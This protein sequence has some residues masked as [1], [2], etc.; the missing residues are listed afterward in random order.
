MPLCPS[1]SLR[2]GRWQRKPSSKKAIV[3]ECRQRLAEVLPLEP[4][5]VASIDGSIRLEGQK[6]ASMGQTLAVAYVYLTTL[7]HRGQHQFP[8]VI[9]SPAGPIDGANRR[10]I[11][12]LVPMLCDQFIAFTI[13]PERM[14][15]VEPLH[16]AAEGDVRYLTLFR[17]TVGTQHLLSNLPQSNVVQDTKTA[18]LIAGKDYFYSFD[19]ID[20]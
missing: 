1:L 13:S 16:Q 9:D 10:E 6:G 18:V 4:V 15:F 2:N 5:S 17:K 7:L 11:A 20:E 14:N 8:L 19:V 12:E 3:A